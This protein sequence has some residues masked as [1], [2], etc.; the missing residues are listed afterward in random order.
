MPLTLEPQRTLPLATP[1]SPAKPPKRKS[2]ARAAFR[3][4]EIPAVAEQMTGTYRVRDQLLFR[5][6][7]VWGLRAHEQLS[8]TIGDICHPDGALKDSFIIG[9][10]RLKGGKPKAPEPPK[11]PDHDTET[12][13]CPKCTLFDGRRQP[14]VK[15]PPAPRHLLILPE[16]KPLLQSWLDAIRATVGDQYGM[17]T[18]LWLSRKTRARKSE[19]PKYRSISRQ[20]YWTIVT[21]ACKKVHLPDFDWHDFGT[22]S[23]RKTIVTQIVADT[24]DIT[25]AQHYVGHANSAMTDKY[26]RAD[27]RKQRE[28][29]LVSAR[30]QWAKTA[31]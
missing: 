3:V 21:N 23:G 22:H 17:D 27:P 11:R 31:A 10:H 7:C 18:P 2:S 12:C 8:M 16:M 26:N 13:H 14:K 25:A 19:T 1:A 29:G 6:N 24:G 5:C 30:K 20:Q 4:E 15:Q 9:S 28:I